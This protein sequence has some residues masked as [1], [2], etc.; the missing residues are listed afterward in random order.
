MFFLI[1]K[2]RDFIDFLKWFCRPR[3]YYYYNYGKANIVFKQHSIEID[4][5][6]FHC[7]MSFFL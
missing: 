6:N 5:F 2:I 3:Q 1:D 7:E 4:I